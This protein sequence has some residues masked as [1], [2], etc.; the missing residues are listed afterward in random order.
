MEW[1]ELAEAS[2]EKISWHEIAPNSSNVSSIGW[3]EE[4]KIDP[5]LLLVLFRSGKC[6]G[7]L[8]VS[9][10]RAVWMATKCDS[11]GTYINRTIKPNF[12]VVRIPELDVGVSDGQT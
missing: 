9:R 10:Q 6:Y 3:L 5:K 7:Y 8:G 1:H 12:E 11:L 2:E 4:I